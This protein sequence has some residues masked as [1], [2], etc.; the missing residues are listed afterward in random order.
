MRKL[1]RFVLPL[2]ICT[3]NI[4]S[5]TVQAQPTKKGFSKRP[6]IILFLVDDMGWQDCSLPFWT[7]KTELNKRYHTPALEKLAQQGMKF[8]QAYATPVCTPT[9]VSVLTGM[10]AAHHGITNWTSPAGNTPTDVADNQFIKPD[11][12]YNGFS[13]TPGV[14]HTVYATP[15]PQILKDAGYYT[16]HVGKAHWAS[17]GTPGSSP[18]NVGF[19]IN[20]AGTSAGH[21]QSYLASDNYGNIPGKATWQA[22]PGLQ[23]YYGSETFLTEALTREA[24]KSLEQPI[25]TKTPFFLNLAHYAVHVPIMADNRFFKKYIDMGLDTLEAAYSTLVEGMDKSLSDVMDF[26]AKNN[27]ADNT[28]IIFLSDNGGLSVPGSRRGKAYTHNAPLKSGKGSV[29]EGGIRIPFVIK[30]PGHT[31]GGSVN[32]YPVIVEDLFPTILE[33]AGIKYVNTVQQRDGIS[34]VPSIN[35]TGNK[36]VRPLIWHI[37]NKWYTDEGPGINFQSAIRLGDWK[38]VYD[39]RTKKRELYNLSQDIGEQQDVSLQYAPIADSLYNML[40]RK[41]N[42]WNAPQPIDKATG[43]AIAMP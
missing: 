25:R 26:L 8:S 41:L 33:M 34:I 19:M 20:I 32:N 5:F 10:N 38:M 28:I 17:A 4:L 39:M 2:W 11:W 1:L 7:Q 6:N 24:L 31:M 37:P 30:W 42:L 43:K 36:T 22:V 14:P 18:F 40:A 12:N 15:F 16:I 9:R 23:E 35:N 13:P 3:V 21:P 29:Y 27:I